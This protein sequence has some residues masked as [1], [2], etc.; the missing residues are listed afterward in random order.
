MSEKNLLT[1]ILDGGVR[2][3][4]FFQGRLLTAE[5]MRGEQDAN[6]TRDRYLGQAVGAGVVD[7]LEVTRQ[8]PT[9]VAP[10]LKVRPGLA[11]NGDGQVLSLSEETEIRLTRSQDPAV[12]APD[13]GLFG[14]CQPPVSDTLAVSSGVFL[15][16]MSPASGFSERAPKTGLKSAGKS[17]AECGSRWAVEGVQLRLQQLPLA[18][19]TGIS[20]AT[21]EQLQ[22]LSEASELHQL[23]LL[24][25]LLAHLCFGTEQATGF[26]NDPFAPRSSQASDAIADLHRNG[27]LQS[28][29]VPLTLLFWAP[30]RGIAFLDPWSVRRRPITG[31]PDRRWPALDL[32]R[33]W[34]VGEAIL[35]QFL[36]QVEDLLR[37]I[38]DPAQVVAQ[39]YFRFLPP[40]GFFPVE[41]SQVRGFFEARFFHDH[42]YRESTFLERSRFDSLLSRSF[43]FPP[44]D[45]SSGE[46][47]W[48]YRVAGSPQG[49][50]FRV[51]ARSSMAFEGSVSKR[52]QYVP[53]LFGKQVV[54]VR[55]LLNQELFD[56]RLGTVLDIHGNFFDPGQAGVQERVVLSQIPPARELVAAGSSIHIA[57]TAEAAASEP[58]EVPQPQVIA[59]SPTPA[60]GIGQ[61]LTIFGANFAPVP[62]DNTVSFSGQDAIPIQGSTSSLYVVVP[63]IVPAPLPGETRQV[64]LTVTLPSGESATGPLLTILPALA[65]APILTGFQESQPVLEGS[66]LRI[67]GEH[68]DDTGPAKNTV[69][70]DNIAVAASSASPS[71]LLVLV[72]A[73][74]ASASTSKAVLV[75]VIVDGQES[76]VLTLGVLG[77][78]E[79]PPPPPPTPMIDSFAPTEVTEGQNVEING[80]NF[81]PDHSE[82]LVVF[83]GE[84]GELSRTPLDGG[85]TQLLVK[86]PNVTSVLSG[87]EAIPTSVIS[88]GQE[89]ADKTLQVKPVIEEPE[90]PP[91]GEPF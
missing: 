30:P 34:A 76:N 31:P 45:L 70:F 59:Y 48:L 15:L 43:E 28:C 61:T 85:S 14:D 90:P 89:S 50:S 53:N 80:I 20:S 22:E 16:V 3:T 78:E 29:D 63:A 71:Q 4:H 75:K 24:R 57:V 66:E 8:D 18:E 7:G 46:P 19:I 64:D 25:N 79:A 62:A 52:T 27:H 55:E 68:F 6:R 12:L 84:F 51:F 36:D 40:A 32:W 60:V 26:A 81:H 38:T 17:A 67:D 21:I 23:S 33:R 58:P 82:N 77:E 9:G 49:A 56:L 72:P 86:V 10:V 1:P 37:A 87:Y 42:P 91:G 41:S 88:N 44:L 2:N 65:P 5:D 83:K 11:V 39:E 54:T 35:L 74:G 73:V 69:F 47:V 13:A